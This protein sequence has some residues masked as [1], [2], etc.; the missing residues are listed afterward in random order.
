MRNKKE[1]LALWFNVGQPNFYM[2]RKH[3]TFV[4]KLRHAV[5]NCK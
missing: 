2:L 4:L 5:K 3:Q 1:G